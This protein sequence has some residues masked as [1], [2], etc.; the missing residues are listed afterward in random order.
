M[1]EAG[2]EGVLG[3]VDESIRKEVRTLL[4]EARHATLATLAP[5]SGHPFASRVGCATNDAGE[6]L[7]LTSELSEHAVALRAD[8]RMSLLLGSVGKGDPLAWPRVTLVGRALFISEKN[9]REQARTHYLARNRKARVYV[10]FP[11]M[12][13]WRLVL[14]RASYN[15][16]FG[17]AFRL[18]QDDFR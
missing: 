18:R 6:V 11:D 16:G 8:T 2:S 5:G 14:E 10:D 4:E 12:Q 1:S 7:F 3:V 17:R 15:G 9:E 13:L